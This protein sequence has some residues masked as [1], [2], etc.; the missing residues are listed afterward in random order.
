MDYAAKI[1]IAA[2]LM[3]R[4][5]NEDERDAASRA[6]ERLRRKAAEQGDKA[7]RTREAWGQY[8]RLPDGWYGEKYAGTYVDNRTLNRMIRA[9]IQMERKIGRRA[10]KPGALKTVNP[11]ADAPKEIRFYV[12]GEYYSGGRSLYVTI[13]GVRTDWWTWRQ[14]YANQPDYKVPTPGPQLAALAKQLWDIGQAYN[15]DRSDSMVDHFDVNFYLHVSADGE[16]TAD[17]GVWPYP[18]DINCYHL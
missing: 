18:A 6:I 10:A 14:P 13:K 2:E 7:S 11:I 12:K 8:Y 1:E 15:Y 17:G 16:P 5:S 4:A 3:R 9:D